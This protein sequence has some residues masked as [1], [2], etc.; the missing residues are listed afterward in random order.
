MQISVPKSPFTQKPDLHDLAD[1]GGL[2]GLS[3]RVYHP[4]IGG[5]QNYK[6]SQL[7]DLI[8]LVTQ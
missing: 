4:E 1:K 8:N 3:T 5:L 2:W 6:S 7:I